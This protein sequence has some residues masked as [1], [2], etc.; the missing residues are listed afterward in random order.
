LNARILTERFLMRSLRV[1][2]VSERYSQW[3]DDEVAQKT[4]LAARAPHALDDLRAYVAARSERDDVL[5]LGIFTRDGG[6][7]IGNV[8]YEPVDR[9]RGYALMGIMIGERSWRGRGVAPEVLKPSAYWL[10][11][12]LAVR[13]FVLGVYKSNTAA[14][15]AYEKVGY[16]V[17]AT[18]RIKADGERSLSMVWRLEP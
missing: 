2:D 16:R 15:K 13:E 17:E 5:F 10:R 9:G 4:I 7:H 12:N 14:I 3:F 18:E 1:E 6:E 11:D 8:K